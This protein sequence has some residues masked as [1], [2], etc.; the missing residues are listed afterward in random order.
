MIKPRRLH[1]LIV[2]ALPAVLCIFT[3]TGCHSAMST[4]QT[5]P[6]SRDAD[7]PPHMIPPPGHGPYTGTVSD[8]PLWFVQHN[9]GGDCFDTQS[10][11]ILYAGF[12]HGSS[13]PSPSIASYGRKHEDL[14]AAPHL[15]IQNFA[16]AAKVKWKSKDGESHTAEIDIAELFRD[17]LIRHNVTRDD[18]PEKISIGQTDILLEVEDRTIN[19]YTRTFIPTKSFRTPGNA[20]SNYRDEL[21]RIFSQTY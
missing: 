8:W 2:A 14:L 18:I 7:T 21:I 19:V 1:P 5:E 16:S 13:Q 15:A 11:E 12:P 4:P 6:A 17:R 3:L 9:F 10:C 20:H